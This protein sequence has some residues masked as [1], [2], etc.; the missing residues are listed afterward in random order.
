MLKIPSSILICGI[1]YKVKVDPSHDG[2]EF[3]E[4]DRTI[5][6]GTSN[7]DKVSNI[8]LHEVIESIAAIRD[9]RYIKQ[10]AEV[11]NGDYLFSFGHDSYE[12]L[13]ADVAASLAGISFPKLAKPK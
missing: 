7:P 6:I 4:E 3:S 1:P 11:N 2:G 13:I 9:L 12:Q 5:I 10:R 8:F